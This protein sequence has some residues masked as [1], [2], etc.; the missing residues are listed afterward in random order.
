M[1]KEPLVYV[2]GRFVEK[3]KAVVSVFDHGLLYGDGVFE[4]IRAYN[5]SVFR[6][7]DHISRLYDSAKVIRLK[8]PIDER[9]MTA[10]VLE[11]MRKNDLR[12]AYIRLVVTRG[13]GDLGVDPALCKSPTVF[14]IAEPMASSL[15]PR[16]PRVVRMIFSSYRRDAVDATSHE[17]KSLNYMNSILAK[18]EASSAGADDAIMLD[19]RGFVSEASVSNIF[20]VKD[21]KL[22]TPS[23]GAGI[24]HGITRRRVISLCSDLGLEVAE[25]DITPFELSTADEVFLVGTKSEVLA[26]GSVGGVDIGTG[27]VGGVTRKLY[28]EF[29][30]VVRRAEEGT[31]VYEPERVRA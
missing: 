14:I 29:S 25:R 4:G 17:I 9:E 1:V 20:I 30:R 23:S 6:L 21:G 5:G 18:M 13:A 24:L 7:A 10:A 3:S 31:P 26:V 15:G 22:S 27:G 2:D 28:G 16:E 11:T 19:H 8:M 12:D